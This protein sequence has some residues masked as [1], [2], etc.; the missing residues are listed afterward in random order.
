MQLFLI[1]LNGFEQ[2]VNESNMKSDLLEAIETF[3]DRKL[4][5]DEIELIEQ[6]NTE[7]EC[8]DNML[9]EISSTAINFCIDNELIKAKQ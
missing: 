8:L 1:F 3:L 7:D 5:E 9:N 4:T 2:I 6:Q